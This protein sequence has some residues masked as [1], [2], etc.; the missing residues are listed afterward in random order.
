MYWIVALLLVAASFAAP[1]WLYPS[2]PDRYPTTVNIE[3]Q[4][5]G[6]GGKSALF[7]FPLMMIPLLLLFYFLPALSP[8]HFEVNAFRRRICI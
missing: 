7:M 6:Y 8:K 4:V 2:L 3:G 5:N 1:A